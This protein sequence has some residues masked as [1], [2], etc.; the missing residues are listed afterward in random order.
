[1]VQRQ[2][3]LADGGAA[4][5]RDAAARADHAQRQRPGRRLVRHRPAPRCCC[6]MAASSSA[7]P[8]CWRS[9]TASAGSSLGVGI[10]AF[11][12]L[13]LLVSMAPPGAHRARA[14]LAGLRAAVG[15]QHDGLAV[16]LHRPRQPLSAGRP[17]F[18]VEATEAVYPFYMIHQTVTVI[19][20]Y[21]LLRSACRALP[22]SLLTV[23][24][25]FGGHLAD[26]RRAVRPWPWIRPL[27]GMKP[28]GRA[29]GGL[30]RL[31]DRPITSPLRA[32]LGGSH[33][34]HRHR[35]RARTRS[36]RSMVRLA[37]SRP[38]I[39]ARPRSRARSTAPRS[40][41]RKSTK[42]SWARS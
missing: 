12:A 40:S 15:D 37:P 20:V 41:P 3:A 34:G 39:S 36:A 31:D 4:R 24:A 1:M 26:L 19:A 29:V 23:L 10:A 7:H 16:R 27:F 8:T 6:S 13:D 32:A 28:P 5:A 14:R 18:L 33:D 17:R 35:Q 9:S 42:S 25:T 2:P 30:A 38:T 22:A 21:W 11:V